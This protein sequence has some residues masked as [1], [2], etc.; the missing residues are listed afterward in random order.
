MN[1]EECRT[2]IDQ[3]DEKILEL[4]LE[5]MN[6]VIEVA[7]YKKERNLPVL[8]PKRE[9]EIIVKQRSKA[10]EELKQYVE[11]LYQTLMETSR[12]YQNELLK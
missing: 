2:R 12:A 3:I 4:Y 9:Q 1:L 6:T 10:P 7:K 11:A 8:H 5:R